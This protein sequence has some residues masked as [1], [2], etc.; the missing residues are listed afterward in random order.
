VP[1]A[2]IVIDNISAMQ[3]PSGTTTTTLTVHLSSE[4]DDPVSVD[5]AT[6]DGTGRRGRLRRHFRDAHVYAPSAQA[7]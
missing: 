3:P 5:Y 6:A 4:M 7:R 1:A 2:E